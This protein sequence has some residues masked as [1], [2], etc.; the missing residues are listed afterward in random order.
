[1]GEMAQGECVGEVTAIPCRA[2][3][4]RALKISN[5]EEEAPK[6]WTRSRQSHRRGKGVESGTSE[7]KFQEGWVVHSIQC[8]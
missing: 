2:L 4:N 7:E 1:M 6:R 8:G 5:L 3:E